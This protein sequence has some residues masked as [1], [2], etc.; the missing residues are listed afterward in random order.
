MAASAA[1]R[2]RRLNVEENLVISG[3]GGVRKAIDCLAATP[4]LCL[5]RRAPLPHTLFHHLPR[6]PLYAHTPATHC[7]LPAFSHTHSSTAPH[8]CLPATAVPL[9]YH[10]CTLPRMR[11]SAHLTCCCPLASMAPRLTPHL[12]PRTARRS[13]PTAP[14]PAICH[15]SLLRRL[16]TSDVVNRR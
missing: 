16:Y 9:L 15:L 13:M 10:L 8:T 1:S 7:A 6:L 2:V 14:L 3:G 11:T 4:R 5:S 12:L